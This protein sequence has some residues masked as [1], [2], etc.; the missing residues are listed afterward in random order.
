MRG[1]DCLVYLAE[2]AAPSFRRNERCDILQGVKL[3]AQAKLQASPEQHQALYCTMTSANEAANYISQRA[4]ETQTFRQYDLHRLV[5]YNTR[6]SFGLSAQMVVRV[7]AKVADAYKLDRRTRREFRPLGSI[8]YDSRILSWSVERHTVSIWTVAGRMTIPFAAGERALRLLEGRAGEADL[9]F[10]DGHFYLFQTCEVDEPPPGEVEAFLGIDLGIVNIA[11]DSEGMTYSG[12]QVNGLRHR[13]R[14][15]RAKLQAKGTRAARRLLAKRRRQESRF[16]RHVNHCISKQIVA[17]AKG[18]GRGIALE[19]LKGIRRRVT[20]R[21][22]QRATLSSWSFAQLGSF[23]RYKAALAGVPVVLV[24]PRN[25]SRTCPQCGTVDRAN[26]PSQAFFSC[27]SCGLA[28]PADTV[29]AVNIGRRAV[30][31]PAILLAP[32]GP[33]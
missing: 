31:N 15:L 9:V 13:H 1:G 16:A 28:G 12:G 25:T 24:D 20:A 29:A 26:R 7:E 19:D 4:W 22:P 30:C 3:T 18:T 2:E 32:A 21:K 10:Q 6:Q 5:Y 23:I 33:G 27:V 17:T 14:R 8:T 11:T